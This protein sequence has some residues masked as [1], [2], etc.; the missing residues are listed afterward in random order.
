MKNPLFDSLVWGS[1][2]L[3]PIKWWES[4]EAKI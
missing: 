1:L 4:D 2:M 3:A